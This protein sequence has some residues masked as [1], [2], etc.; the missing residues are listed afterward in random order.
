MRISEIPLISKI[1]EKP[2]PIRVLISENDIL[3]LKALDDFGSPASIFRED[4]GLELIDWSRSVLRLRQEG[5]I[6]NTGE[7]GPFQY[8]IT[9]KGRRVR[10]KIINENAPQTGHIWIK[11]LPEETMQAI[12]SDEEDV[13][14]KL[15]ALLSP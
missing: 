11:I 12:E 5:L 7:K 2:Q 6:V 4:S 8:Q 3:T 9:D 13:D 10:S 15:D 14:S 1:F